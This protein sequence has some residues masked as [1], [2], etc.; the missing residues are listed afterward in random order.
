MCIYTYIHIYTHIYTYIHIYTHIYMCIHIYIFAFL[1]KGRF[2]NQPHC[3]KNI[4]HSVMD[5]YD[6]LGKNLS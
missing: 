2:T 1:I 5:T 6:H 4:Y 3:N